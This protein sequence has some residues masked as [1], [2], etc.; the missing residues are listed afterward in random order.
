MRVGDHRRIADPINS[1]HDP[2][3]PAGATATQK[4]W[5]VSGGIGASTGKDREEGTPEAGWE[6]IR[7]ELR[8]RHGTGQWYNP[9]RG[10]QNRGCTCVIAM[11]YH[12]GKHPPLPGHLVGMVRTSASPRMRLEANERFRRL[13]R[14]GMIT[15]SY[16]L[17]PCLVQH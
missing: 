12:Q 1:R 13:A 5:S 2:N 10:V 9:P 4:G 3:D 11:V 14:L 8:T 7:E 6:A 16:M 17:H 15:G